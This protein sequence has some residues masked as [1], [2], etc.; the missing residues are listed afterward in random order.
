MFL[1]H[2]RERKMAIGTARMAHLALPNSEFHVGV[3]FER[4]ARIDQVVASPGTFLLFPGPS[5]RDITE[6]EPGEL[7]T[8][9]VVD[10]TWPL[11]K[12]LIRVN[13]RL[14]TLPRVM[15]RPARPGNYR[16]RKEPA[17]H[18]VSTIEAVVEI[19]GHLEG[20][21]ERY[22]EMLRAFDAMVDTQIAHRD[23]RQGPSRY[24]LVRKPRTRPTVAER[25]SQELSELGSRLV[26]SY[27]ESNSVPNEDGT[28]RHELLH[29][30]AHRCGG[31]TFE[32]LIRPD[33]A[34]DASAPFHAE[35]SSEEILA[36]ESRGSAL[37][38]W[39]AFLREGDVL[40]G[41]GYFTHA[42][43]APHA[44]GHAYLDLRERLLRVTR[45]KV[46][47]LDEA[48]AGV[49]TMD[50]D[51]ASRGRAGR[52]MHALRTLHRALVE[53]RISA[54]KNARRR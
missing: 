27:A 47:G 6:L 49:P 12:K 48:V 31:E 5:A 11:A 4:D 25:V 16:I 10:G 37:A 39:R 46:G 15:F 28:R 30:V 22:R 40:A 20:D 54:G 43:V 35:L 17:E 32:A 8:L 36:G 18:C 51:A 14:Q 9:L 50:A 29:L 45:K 2:L 53:R 21:A 44:Q 13:P 19:L 26:L 1:Q 34:L 38:R 52:R 23:E 7:K 41:W 3:D 33:E 24:A 42:L